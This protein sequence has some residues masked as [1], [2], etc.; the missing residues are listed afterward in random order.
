[1]NPPSSYFDHYTQGAFAPHVTERHLVCSSGV[2]MLD[3]VQPAGAYP[4]PPL[5][6]FVLQRDMAGLSATVDFGAGRFQMRPEPRAMAIA[7]PMSASDI[8]V[9]TPHHV[10]IL[11]IPASRVSG[12]MQSEK[13]AAASRDLGRLHATGFKNILIEQLLDRLWSEAADDEETSLLQK[14][15]VLLTLW[16]ELLRE[17]RK[18]LNPIARGGLAPWQTRRCT[19][20]LHEHVTENVGLEQLAALV[21]LSPFHFARAFKQSTG[22]PPHRYHLK[23]RI[24]KAKA[25]LVT[26]DAPVT[27]IALD[28]GYES[29]QALAR[30]FRREVGVSPSDY[31][32]LET[33]RRA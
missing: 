14:D 15:A 21:G 13:Q 22:V 12:W 23:A 16:G 33:G 2:W 4:D 25:L 27:E 26:T 9:H 7:P 11:A 1:M 3:V 24:E 17:A 18:P 20:F 19:D 8:V 30:L 32:R 5:P 28:V 29:S 31:R 6:E 10:R